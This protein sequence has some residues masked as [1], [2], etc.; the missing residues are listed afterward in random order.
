MTEF[1][2]DVFLR[3]AQWKSLMNNATGLKHCV[4]VL[5]DGERNHQFDVAHGNIPETLHNLLAWEDSLLYIGYLPL[6]DAIRRLV[7]IARARGILNWRVRIYSVHYSYCAHNLGSNTIINSRFML[8]IVIPTFEIGCEWWIHPHVGSCPS[9]F[10]KL[11]MIHGIWNDLPPREDPVP[12]D[13]SNPRGVRPVGVFNPPP[14]RQTMTCTCS[15]C[16]PYKRCMIDWHLANC[17]HSPKYRSALQYGGCFPRVRN[18]LTNARDASALLEDHLEKHELIGCFSTL[19]IPVRTISH[20]AQ[21]WPAIFG[22]G[23]PGAATGIDL[24]P[25]PPGPFNAP[26]AL[27][28]CPRVFRGFG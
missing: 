1:D 19:D 28:I 9:S 3:E 20:A 21:A 7:A 16:Y 6:I 8:A 18:L 27:I 15:L 13:R 2:T 12:C 26:F 17:G 22:L 5:M 23:V 25:E 11:E 24:P 4:L 10:E 14:E